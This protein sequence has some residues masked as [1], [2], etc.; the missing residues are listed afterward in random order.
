[1]QNENVQIQ[2]VPAPRRLTSSNSMS[3]DAPNQQNGA[4]GAKITDEEKEVWYDLLL[5]KYLECKDSI[6]C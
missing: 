2:P 3:S 1:M 6:A 5:V 4:P